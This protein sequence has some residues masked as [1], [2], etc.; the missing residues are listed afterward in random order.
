MVKGFKKVT[1]TIITIAVVLIAVLQINAFVSD[2]RKASEARDFA[3]RACNGYKD[4]ESIGR[5]RTSLSF[6]LQASDLD[7][8]YRPLA[9]YIENEYAYFIAYDGKDY[10]YILNP[11][12]RDQEL[13]DRLVYEQSHKSG[14][15]SLC[16]G[17]EMESAWPLPWE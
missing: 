17:W 7:V 12:Q 5:L 4:A 13:Y 3:L 15:T 8:R 1:L 14:I 2:G 16:R 6:A 9:D 10:F 11:D